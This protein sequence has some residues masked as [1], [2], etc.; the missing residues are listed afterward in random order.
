[1]QKYSTRKEPFAQPQT[2]H[3]ANA[4]SKE[5]DEPIVVADQHGVVVSWPDKHT[6]RF[7]WADLRQACPCEQC[8]AVRQ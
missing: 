3:L 1:M 2:Q 4:H 8:R 6:S 5:K 7:F